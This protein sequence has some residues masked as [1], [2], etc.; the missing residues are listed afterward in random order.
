L[1]YINYIYFECSDQYR[2]TDTVL[3]ALTNIH[4]LNISY[5]N[6][7]LIPYELLQYLYIN[8]TNIS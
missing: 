1:K 8:G 6:E 2:I 4:S 5:R 3:K 7:N